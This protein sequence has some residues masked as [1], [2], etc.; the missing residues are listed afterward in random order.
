MEQLIQELHGNSEALSQDP[1]VSIERLAE[2]A[3]VQKPKKPD[4]P[5]EV[6]KVKTVDQLAKAENPKK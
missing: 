2:L 1:D 6:D 5:K 4:K 3:G